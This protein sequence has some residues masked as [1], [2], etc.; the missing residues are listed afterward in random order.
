MEKLKI[1]QVPHGVV[2]DRA[3][4]KTKGIQ[5]ALVDYYLRTGY[6]ERVARG[7]YRRPGGLLKWQN[8]V[9]SLQLLGFSLHVG[10]RSAL[11]LKGRAHYLPLDKRPRL[12]LYSD[13]ALPS[14]IFKTGA[15]EEFVRH[16]RTLFRHPQNGVSDVV[17]G[18]WDWRIN[19][20]APERAL[21]EMMAEVPNKESFAMV[22]RVMEGATTLRPDVVQSLLFDC[23]NIKVK[24]LFLW[25]SEKYKHP[26]FA[27]LN[28]DD[29]DLGK[30]K[31]VVQRNGMLD[32]KYLI[33][34]PRE[35][36]DQ[37]EQPLF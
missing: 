26:W 2:V 32:P 25:F 27:K 33:T 8:L 22:A 3:W 21:F 17:F 15:F 19:V 12:H 37:Q 13:T 36:D 5:P 1:E 16:T 7:A 9:Y 34:V 28:S 23:K 24:R 29:V 18:S 20:S 6:L 35:S 10:G 11:E 4:L 31:R 14:W 30:G